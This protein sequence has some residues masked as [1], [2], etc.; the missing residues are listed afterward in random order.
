MNHWDVMFFNSIWTSQ[1]LFHKKIQRHVKKWGET[2]QKYERFF[3]QKH[4]K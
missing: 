2:R 4:D 3:A 1:F